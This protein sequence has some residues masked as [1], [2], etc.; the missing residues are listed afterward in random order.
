MNHSEEF[1]RVTWAGANMPTSWANHSGQNAPGE[2]HWNA[3]VDNNSNIGLQDSSTVWLTTNQR[4]YQSEPVYERARKM[5]DL[6]REV[7][8]QKKLNEI[9]GL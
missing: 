8:F 9:K 1:G 4:V 7:E 3:I 2:R 6:K 5:M